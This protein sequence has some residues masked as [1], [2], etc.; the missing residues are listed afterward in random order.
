MKRLLLLLLIVAGCSSK[1][2]ESATA[3]SGPAEVRHKWGVET[4][5]KTY[6]ASVDW[7][8]SNSFIQRESGGIV[9]V[10]PIGESKC[11][12]YFTDGCSCGLNLEVQGKKG[13]ALIQMSGVFIDSISQKLYVPGA[14]W[15]KNGVEMKLH[16]NGMTY[17]DY[18]EPSH[19]LK[20]LDQE[21]SAYHSFHT[22][23]YYR[24]QVNCLLGNEE[25]AL[26]DIRSAIQKINEEAKNTVSYNGWNKSKK[27]VWTRSN[28]DDLCNAFRVLAVIQA[29]SKT[30]KT[31]VSK[32]LN[33]IESTPFYVDLDRTHE[34]Y[35]F[36]WAV[37][38][39]AGLQDLANSELAS[40]YETRTKNVMN[41][42]TQVA[43]YY[44]NEKS[45]DEIKMFGNFDG[46]YEAQKLYLDGNT[47]KARFYLERYLKGTLIERPDHRS[48]LAK[49]L[50]QKLTAMP[51][52]KS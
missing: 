25:K 43:P 28:S 27:G 36:S 22:S 29:F 17:A 38:Q 42:F 31:N 5:G 6:T 19:W 33:E 34:D 1:Y 40:R 26:Q 12:C 46:F 16:R 4:F 20:E 52:A 39:H 13:A 8:K 45:A 21:I 49:L 18:Y 7:I 48:F 14:V 51:I 23:F 44:L 15:K 32:T 3:P 10:A 37:L 24:A 41:I 47:E 11:G 30:E 50:I 2:P 9:S 35:L